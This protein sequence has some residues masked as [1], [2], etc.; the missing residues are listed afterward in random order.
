MQRG[1]NLGTLRC[2]R[3]RVPLCSTSMTFLRSTKGLRG[4]WGLDMGLGNAGI[5]SIGNLSSGWRPPVGFPLQTQLHTATVT[6]D[7]CVAPYQALSSCVCS[8]IP[9]NNPKRLNFI[10]PILQGRNLS[11]GEAKSFAPG[12]IVPKWHWRDSKPALS[13]VPRRRDCQFIL[14]W[15]N[16]CAQLTFCLG[17]QSF[18]SVPGCLPLWSLIQPPSCFLRP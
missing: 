10:I 2:G 6:W 13:P 8:S 17:R 3:R 1:D 11:L 18:R 7:I 16:G 5:P 12:I 9:H 15:E 14:I 4:G